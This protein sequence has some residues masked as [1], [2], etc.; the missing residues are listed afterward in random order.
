MCLTVGGLHHHLSCFTS[1]TGTDDTK[2]T[3]GTLERMEEMNP[4]AFPTSSKVANVSPLSRR[5][6]REIESVLDDPVYKPS[7]KRLCRVMDRKG[8]KK[9]R[10]E[11]EA[12][13]ENDLGEPCEICDDPWSYDD[14]QILLVGA[15][16]PP[17]SVLSLD[18]FP[19]LSPSP[20]SVGPKTEPRDVG[21]DSICCASRPR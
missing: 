16:R 9:K 13:E 1:H 15:S 19:L 12:E 21:K 6:L 10:E 20:R 2:E 3:L 4:Y 7:I 5:N 11:E 8:K 18:L 14:N 17:I